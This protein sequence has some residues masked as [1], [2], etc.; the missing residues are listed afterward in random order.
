MMQTRRR[1]IQ[2]RLKAPFRDFTLYSNFS[3]SYQISLIFLL[4]AHSLSLMCSI[5]VECFSCLVC[6]LVE[7]PVAVVLPL[8]SL[9]I[10]LIPLLFFA[11]A[12]LFLSACLT[13]RATLDEL[14]NM[15]PN[16]PV[17]HQI[18]RARTLCRLKR[19]TSLTRCCPLPL[20]PTLLLLLISF[21]DESLMRTS[22]S[23]VCC[24]EARRLANSRVSA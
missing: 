12:F 10:F 7:G 9:F 8:F 21:F 16:P 14:K 6:V 22:S 2:V 13:L 23:V 1:G 11:I 19:I 20:P 17:N 3:Q 24:A 15:M 5:I 4:L 18:E